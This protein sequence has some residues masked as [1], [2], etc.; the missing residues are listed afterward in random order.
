MLT[1]ILD[2]N[3]LEKEFEE[4]VYEENRK[5]ITLLELLVNKKE[6]SPSASTVQTKVYYRDPS[7][8]AYVKKRANGCCQLCGEKAPFAD[9]NGDPYLEC[10]HIEWLSKGGLDSI[11]NCVALCPNCHRRMH[12][13]NDSKDINVLKQSICDL[14]TQC[15]R[16]SDPKTR[17]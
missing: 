2:A 1:L 15:N 13:L 16:K 17:P 10:H 11:N 4:K 7:I 12:I 14:S 9:K 5:T 8:A 6:S 3:D